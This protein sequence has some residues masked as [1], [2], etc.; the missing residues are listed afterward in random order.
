[1]IENQ[2]KRETKQTPMKPKLD[3]QLK[4]HLD[5]V[6]DGYAQM[7]A[8]GQKI[9]L[10]DIL[11]DMLSAIMKKERDIFLR[12]IPEESANGF[13]GRTLQ[14][15][16]GKLDLKIPRIRSSAGFRPALLP[17]K[18]KRVD[19][20]YEN[21]LLS[22][23]T[24]GY[25]QSQIEKALHSLGLPYS[26]EALDELVSL[27]HERSDFYRVSTLPDTMFA[28]FM[29]PP[30]KDE[31]RKQPGQGHCHLYRPWNR[32]GRMQVNPWVL[33]GRRQRVQGILG[34]R[35]PGSH[36]KG[37]QKSTPLCNR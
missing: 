29:I 28:V 15:A 36:I 37:A 9:G 32:H 10:D 31:D 2:E 21:L 24:N 35:L 22:F 17:E 12:T 30:H 18:W 1:M 3:G 26:Q 8:Q 16:I 27:I 14:L 25:S 20:D 5:M 13:Y 23:L 4:D 7:I 11:E 19:K 6:A 33:G 34:R